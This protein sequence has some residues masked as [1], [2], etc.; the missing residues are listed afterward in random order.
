MVFIFPPNRGSTEAV[1]SLREH[2]FPRN[3]FT[4][5]EVVPRM[6]VELY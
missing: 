1:P 4:S 5:P 2:V 6:K 3:S